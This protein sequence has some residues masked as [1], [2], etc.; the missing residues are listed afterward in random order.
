MK[1]TSLFIFIGLFVMAASTV[2]YGQ[3]TLP[4]GLGKELQDPKKLR[5]I[6]ENGD[7]RFVIVDVRGEH[8]YASGHIP[9]AIN[10]PTTW[11]KGIKHIKD[12]PEKDKYLILY[13]YRSG[14]LARFA[15]GRLRTAGYKY[16]LVWGGITKWPYKLERS[17]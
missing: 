15:E 12:P 2:S 3:D 17:D 4:D 1:K 7:P 10:M 9:T 13:C 6:I 11:T 16:M 5:A 8:S 14:G